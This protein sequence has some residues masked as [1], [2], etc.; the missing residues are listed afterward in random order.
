MTVLLVITAIYHLTVNRY[1]SPLETYMPVD[2]LSGED[3]ESPLLGEQ[4]D[5]SEQSRV[6]RLGAGKVPPVLLDPLAAFLEPHIFASQEA[7]RPWLQDPEGESEE[8]NSYS[9][10]QLRNAYLNPALTSKTP[11]VWLP[12]D[13]KSVS[14][15]EIDENEKAGVSSTDDGAELSPSNK[16]VWNQEDFTTVPIFKEPTRY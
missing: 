4:A 12:K 10:E 13:P 2:V 16:I 14:K 15:K 5:V 3:D 9:D 6:Y 8:S 7:L 1:L 11:K